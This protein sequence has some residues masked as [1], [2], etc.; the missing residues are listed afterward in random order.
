[1]NAAD[2]C[3]SLAAAAVIGVLVCELALYAGIAWRHRDTWSAADLL[4]AT[5]RSLTR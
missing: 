3:R 1:M 2:L 4:T 5:C